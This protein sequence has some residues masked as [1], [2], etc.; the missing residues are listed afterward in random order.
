M[1]N[2]RLK[3]GD[4]VKPEKLKK[5]EDNLQKVELGA[6]PEK[7]KHLEDKMSGVATNI[8]GDTDVKAGEVANLVDAMKKSLVKELAP[9]KAKELLATLKE[10]FLKKDK[11]YK[12][13][14]GI[15]WKNVQKK[16]E[17]NP[18]K[19]WSLNEMERTGGEPDV[20][21][22][23]SKRN[24]YI[25]MDSSTEIPIGRRNCCYD[26]VGQQQAEKYS[27]EP[28]SNA[29]S[30]AAMMGI[31]LLTE[32]A[33]MFLQSRGVFDLHSRCWLKI[34]IERRKKGDTIVGNRADVGI[35]FGTDFPH[36]YSANQGFR[37][38]LKV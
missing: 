23:D 27:A 22:W 19:L 33:Y 38:M 8:E 16:L 15:Q 30:M 12:S 17:T 9:E 3:L 10:R 1:E 4:L 18:E 32:K 6:K 31:N 29:V 2:K 25:F 37:G 11:H 7:I 20:F 21:G 35:I 24:E 14:E 13:V 28:V 5:P 34:S 26:R 36:D